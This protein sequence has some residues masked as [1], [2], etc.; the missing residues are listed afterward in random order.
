V[1]LYEVREQEERFIGVTDYASGAVERCFG[2][3]VA[4]IPVVFA[5][6]PVELRRTVH[7]ALR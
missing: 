2:A 5:E 1:S 3:V 6:L 7:E 4:P